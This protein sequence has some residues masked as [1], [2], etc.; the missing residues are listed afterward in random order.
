L[1]SPQ[2]EREP[3]IA[4]LFLRPLLEWP[5]RYLFLA[6]A[7]AFLL[8]VS[9][10]WLLWQLGLPDLFWHEEPWRQFAAGF[11]VGM[12][13]SN[14]GVVAFLLASRE[15]WIAGLK[16][17]WPE[18]GPKA[19]ADAL[20][21]RYVAL[22]TGPLLLVV[23]ATTLR[24]PDHLHGF[25]RWALPLGAVTGAIVALAGIWWTRRISMW[26]I[27]RGTLAGQVIARIDG[28]ERPDARGLAALHRK[29]RSRRPSV[30][31]TDSFHRAAAVFFVGQLIFFFAGGLLSVTRLR[32]LLPAGLV[33]AMFLSAAVSAYGALRWRYDRHRFRIFGGL[34][35][36]WVALAAWGPYRHTLYDLRHEYD[37]PVPAT[38]R[39]TGYPAL[40]D[41]TAVLQAWGQGG[42][43]PLVVL[44]VDGGGI[45]AATWT[46]SVLTALEGD[47]P[48]FPY[49]VRVIAGASGG[50]V[51]AAYYVS[52]LQRPGAGLEHHALDATGALDRDL[53]I[54]A[55]AKDSLEPTAQRLVFR[56]IFPVGFAAYADRGYALERA[57]EQNTGTLD[58]PFSALRQGESEG[59]R[60]SLIFS[61]MIVEDGRRLLISHLDL[62]SLTTTAVPGIGAVRTPASLSALEFLKLVPSAANLHVSTVARMSASFAYVS[63]AAELPTQ[64]LRRVVD[65]GYYDEHGVDLAT[66][67][68]L[69]NL[70]AVRQRASKVVLIQIP[71]QRTEPNR[72]PDPC[73]PPWWSR[74]LSDFLSPPEGIAASWSAGMNF[75]NDHAVELLDRVLNQDGADYFRSYVFEPYRTVEVPPC[76]YAGSGDWE[77]CAAR[78]CAELDEERPVALSWH[79]VTVKRDLLSKAPWSTQNCRARDDL[80]RWWTSDSRQ[81]AVG[82]QSPSMR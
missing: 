19:E 66:A 54:K 4:A 75:R 37:R 41:S 2:P 18:R 11:G 51:G 45:R 79:M 17:L 3:T 14:T 9:G 44:A 49:H 71:D 42:P 26:L 78:Y 7:T 22:T 59:W 35:V 76:L 80:V 8:G 64:P 32:W 62:A 25:G 65:A 53:M 27:A 20:V 82:C 52:T 81:S 1:P 67:W 21:G 74:G 5:I 34:V 30:V 57:W 77:E 63:P 29:Y 40:L 16:R 12:F 47:I 70:D 23:V 36:V 56:D 28:P 39:P 33:L 69:A 50:M 13:L 48:E 10:N 6:L 46:T 60:P 61:P 58:M 15:K 72:L 73:P 55:I 31:D 24:A 38:V 68:I 43:K